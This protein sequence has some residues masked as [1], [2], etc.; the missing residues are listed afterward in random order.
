MGV[1]IAS[2]DSVSKY[3]ALKM[4]KQCLFFQSSLIVLKYITK[5]LVYV[6][7]FYNFIIVYVLVY[8]IH[9]YMPTRNKD[10]KRR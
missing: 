9:A 7:V 6:L 1:K 2:Y 4:S 3:G 10:V 8:N 5:S